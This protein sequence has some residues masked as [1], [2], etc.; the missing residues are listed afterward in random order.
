MPHISFRSRLDPNFRLVSPLAFPVDD[1][2]RRP[3][4][5]RHRKLPLSQVA[6]VAPEYQNRVDIHRLTIHPDFHVFP[7]NPMVLRSISQNAIAFNRR[8]QFLVEN[9]FSGELPRIACTQAHHPGLCRGRLDAAATV[10]WFGLGRSSAIGASLTGGRG[11]SRV[12]HPGKEITSRVLPYSASR[13]AASDFTGGLAGLVPAQGCLRA[14]DTLFDPM[15]EEADDGD[16]R[17]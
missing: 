15:P 4:P 9:K 13:H 1:A 16:G 12:N 5:E 6:G 14:V 3:F 8:W 7:E 17:D 11:I 10:V 2:S